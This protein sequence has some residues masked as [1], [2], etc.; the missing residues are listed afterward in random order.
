MNSAV[1]EIKKTAVAPSFSTRRGKAENN[2]CN[3][4]TYL[5]VFS[6]FSSSRKKKHLNSGF[7]F[8]SL[9]GNRTSRLI[10]TKTYGKA[11][12]AFGTCIHNKS[13]N[14]LHS[15]QK[16]KHQNFAFITVRR[17]YHPTNV[18]LGVFGTK[19]L[20]VVSLEENL[21]HIFDESDV[22]LAGFLTENM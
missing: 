1:K 6:I 18:F 22:I 17:L 11:L 9:V 21:C 4:G 19:E 5:Y 14:N 10:M 3:I 13:K 8:R 7:I 2:K 20:I 15:Q 16:Q 12:T